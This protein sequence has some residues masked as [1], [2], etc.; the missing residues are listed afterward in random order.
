MLLFDTECNDGTFG[1][2]C[3]NNCS[4]HCLDNSPCNKQI[5]HCNLGCDPGY[6]NGDCSKGK[7][8]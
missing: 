3:T 8:K 1:Y 7:Y 5:G 2:D 4:G 6:T